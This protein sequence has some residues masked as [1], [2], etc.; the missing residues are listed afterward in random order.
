[1]AEKA[2][3]K[4]KL[5]GAVANVY[6]AV[7]ANDHLMIFPQP[8]TGD[9]PAQLWN[10]KRRITL[11][12]RRV[13]ARVGAVRCCHVSEAWLSDTGAGTPSEDPDR[14]EIVM[15]IA[16]DRSEGTIQASMPVIRDGELAT[17]GALEIAVEPGSAATIEGLM[18]GLLPR[19]T[20]Q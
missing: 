1:M 11:K 12:M 19:G 16:E 7:D 9:T 5:H 3:K 18:I 14:R 4:F 15:L 17:L 20:P 2:E 6:M 13:F 8:F 10:N